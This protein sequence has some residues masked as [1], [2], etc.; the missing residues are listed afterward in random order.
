MKKCSKCGL[1]SPD[2][3]KFCPECGNALNNLEFDPYEKNKGFDFG[4][5]NNNNSRYSLLKLIVILILLVIYPLT[6]VGLIL[7]WILKI[8]SNRI[9]RKLLTFI[10]IIFAL[11]NIYTKANI[12][13]DKIS[14]SETSEIS[15]KSTEITIAKSSSN[16]LSI[17]EQVI[18]NQNNTVIKVKNL[19]ETSTEIKINIYI[20]NNSNLNLGFNAHAYGINGI[21]AGNN[22]YDMDCDVAAGKMANTSITIQKSFLDKV[23]IKNFKFM[24]IIFWAYD[25]DKNYKEFETNVCHVSTSA[26][27]AKSNVLTGN[28]IYNTDGISVDYLSSKDNQYTFVLTNTTGSYIDFDIDNLT[29]NDYTDS[30]IDYDLYNEEVLNNNQYIFTIKVSNDFLKNN[31]INNISKL[32]FEIKYR[33]NGSYEN[34]KNTNMIEYKT[35]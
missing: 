30:D 16:P 26:D 4:N 22:I 20:E 10:F 32:E 14:S 29:I 34:E 9:F 12:P 8:P 24:D 7:I 25:N 15:D 27:D 33:L 1:V 35:T 17:K 21:M 28:N 23:G 18:Y 2:D 3:T 11:I 6:Y 5:N 13:S 19:E 31:V